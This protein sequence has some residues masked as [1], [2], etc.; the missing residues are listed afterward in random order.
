MQLS[1]KQLKSLVHGVLELRQV[2]GYFSFQRFSP[3]QVQ[4]LGFSADF[5]RISQYTAGVSMR[6]KSDAC[7]ISFEY[8]RIR[9]TLKDSIDVYANDKLVHAFLMENLELEGTLSI[10]LPTGEKD[11]VIYFPTDVEIQIKNFRIDGKWRSV[12]PKKCK[13][14][15]IGDSITQGVG[16]FMGSQT[17]VNLVSKKIGCESLNQGIGGYGYM[18]NALKFLSNFEADKIVVALG[19]ND[20][21]DGLYER[22][23]IFYE[24]LNNVYR[25]L[26]TLV[27]TP[28]WRGDD[29]DKCCGLRTIKKMIEDVCCRYENIRVVDGFDL[30]PPVTYCFYDNLHPNAWGMEQYANNLLKEIRRLRF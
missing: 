14:L 9:G 22:I 23:E 10:S 19:T 3:E 18:E 24:T 20:G 25:G 6:F 13:I 11:A 28:I 5:Q 16:S 21:L 27:I 1:A 15:W 2:E 8:K 4:S 26:P 7:K 12:K 17:F 29:R 30:V